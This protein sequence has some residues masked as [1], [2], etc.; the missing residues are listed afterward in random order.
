M[1]RSKSLRTSSNCDTCGEENIKFNVG[2]NCTFTCWKCTARKFDFVRQL[3]RETGVE[4]TNTEKY[5][6]ALSEW[7]NQ[8]RLKVENKMGLAFK[9]W[10][11]KKG[12]SREST[13]LHLGI[14]NDYLKK[15]E[16]GVKPLIPKMLE[17][18]DEET[19]T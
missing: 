10:R 3:E 11:K 15:M 7:G 19:H 1:Q 17:F 6:R 18:L 2:E 8:K 13:A 5:L 9:D 12:W 4:I 14:S 16:N